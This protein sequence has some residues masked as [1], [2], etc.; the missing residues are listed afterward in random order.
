VS[1]RPIAAH[2]HSENSDP[3][4]AASCYCN[5]KEPAPSAHLLGTHWV[6]AL[7]ILVVCAELFGYPD[8]SWR[9][10]STIATLNMRED[11]GSGGHISIPKGEPL[12]TLQGS[13]ARFHQ[14]HNRGTQR[15]RQF[16][17]TWDRGH[18][19]SV[20]LHLRSPVKAAFR[21]PVRVPLG[22]RTPYVPLRTR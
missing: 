21:E 3:S 1:R 16:R 7:R 11:I 18:Q 22:G 12:A 2:C 13:S 8:H 6:R 4:G 9:S 20:G 5:K 14:A 17:P 19:A 10:S 15:L